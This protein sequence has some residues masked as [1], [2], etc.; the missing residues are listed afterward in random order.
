MQGILQGT[1]IEVIKGETRSLDYGSYVHGHS[2]V[3]D[4]HAVKSGS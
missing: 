4:S 3:A 1:T 2:Y